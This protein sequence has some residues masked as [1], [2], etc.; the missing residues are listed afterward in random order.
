MVDHATRADVLRAIK[1]YDRLGPERFFSEHG[2]APTTTYELAWE[3]RRYPPKAILGT[4]YEFA[5]GERLGS[6]DFEGGKSGPSGCSDSWASPF[7]RSDEQPGKPRRNEGGSPGTPTGR[8]RK[9]D[10]KLRAGSFGPRL[11][12]V[13]SSALLSAHGDCDLPMRRKAEASRSAHAT[14][15][16]RHDCAEYDFYR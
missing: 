14:E 11:D 6:G 10:A 9:R 15:G 3:G 7:R 1:E 12:N 2:F 13:L 8:H 4:A 16:E 5:T